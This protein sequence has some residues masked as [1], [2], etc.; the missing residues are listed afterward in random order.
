MLDTSRLHVRGGV[1]PSS[2]NDLEIVAVIGRLYVV[3]VKDVAEAMFEGWPRPWLPF[4]TPSV[5]LWRKGDAP[6]IESIE[7]E[8]DSTPLMEARFLP[9]DFV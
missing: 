3:L 2:K 4:E 5:L 8:E 1:V 6:F 9:C 7:V